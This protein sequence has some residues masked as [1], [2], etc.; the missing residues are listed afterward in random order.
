MFVSI[1]EP[2]DYLPGFRFSV[3]VG[4]EFTYSSTNATHLV[5]EYFP[6]EAQRAATK[7]MGD[8]MRKRAAGNYPKWD[9][10]RNP[11]PAVVDSPA[12]QW[13]EHISRPLSRVAGV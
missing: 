7:D 5:Q 2:N 13:E 11:L 8:V 4:V 9:H 3:P 1:I 10:Y 12:R 6:Y